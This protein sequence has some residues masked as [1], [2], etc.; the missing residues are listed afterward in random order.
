MQQ[1]QILE[2]ELKWKEKRLETN[3][4]KEDI[5]SWQVTAGR[6]KYIDTE[7]SSSAEFISDCN[8]VKYQKNGN[9]YINHIDDDFNITTDEPQFAVS[10]QEYGYRVD[11]NA[12]VEDYDEPLT[13]H[14]ALMSKGNSNY[15]ELK[16]LYTDCPKQMMCINKVTNKGDD[17]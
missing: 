3:N 13:A 16:K 9:W 2:I 6:I 4:K 17:E 5:T 11:M 14:L 8:V 12:V 10:S 1:L 15:N 7:Q